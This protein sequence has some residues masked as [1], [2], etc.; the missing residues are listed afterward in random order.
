MFILYTMSIYIYIYIYT[1]TQYCDVVL[2]F[3]Q[4]S[5]VF[6]WLKMLLALNFNYCDKELESDSGNELELLYFLRQKCRLCL[7]CLNQTSDLPNEKKATWVWHECEVRFRCL[8]IIW[9]SWLWSSDGFGFGCPHVGKLG[10]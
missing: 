4:W 2:Y 3:L 9:L 5:T 6:F 1:H 10:Y 8:D 7:A